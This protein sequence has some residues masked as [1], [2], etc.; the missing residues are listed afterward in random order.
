M[1]KISYTGI[2]QM[3]A[4]F[5]RTMPPLGFQSKPESP[6]WSSEGCVTVRAAR[7]PLDNADFAVIETFPVDIG[8]SVNI[9]PLTFS[10]RP[11]RAAVA[12]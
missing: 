2:P 11:E 7:R 5:L 1:I 4:N 12:R 9:E 8:E 10:I 3:V 6:L